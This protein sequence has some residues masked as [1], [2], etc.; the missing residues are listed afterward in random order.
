MATQ[1]FQ[2]RH[3]EQMREAGLL[4]PPT[5]PLGSEVQYSHNINRE[6]YYA[7][8]GTVG[9]VP[10][11]RSRVATRTQSRCSSTL[12]VSRSTCNRTPGPSVTTCS[13]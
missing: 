12:V 1:D 4:P 7:E 2:D 11:Q 10:C 6:A 8:H 13:T 9:A 5:Q 3:Y